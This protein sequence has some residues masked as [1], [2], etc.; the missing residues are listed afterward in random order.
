MRTK[1]KKSNNLR[2]AFYF[3]ILVVFFGGLSLAFKLGTV[4]KN[5]TFDGNHRYNMEVRED[6][7]V[8]IISFS[9]QTNNIAI[10]NIDDKI[11]ESMNK[12]LSIPIDAK[13][14]GQCP[15]SG[16]D[17]FQ[18]LTKL[19]P[20]TFDVNS[21]PTF[22]DILKLMYFAKDIP[23][24]SISKN[25]IGNSPDDSLK[26]QILSSEFLDQ[27]IVGE[28]KTIQIINATAVSGLGARLAAMLSNIGGNIILVVTMEK[29]AKE[30]QIT[31][32]GQE[33][34]TV[35]K[36][37]SILGFKKEKKNGRAIADIIIIIGKDVVNTNKF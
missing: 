2:F 19:L 12:E 36:L 16:S 32:Y 31:Y 10:V 20:T 37:H 14:S 22:I 28:K 27:S 17:I 1:K 15:I 34:Y 5:S 11:G 7:T 25:T 24:E 3:I 18:K 21:K 13:I 23:K 33:S 26:Q 35:Q 4:L 29:E 8:C 30:S 9:P 6:N